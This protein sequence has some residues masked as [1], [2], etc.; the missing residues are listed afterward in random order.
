MSLPIWL[1]EL[2]HRMM[3]FLSILCMVFAFFTTTLPL[4]LKLSYSLSPLAVAYSSYYWRRCIVLLVGTLVPGKLPMLYCYV[5]GGLVCLKI[6]LLLFGVVPFVSPQSLALKHP[7]VNC[8]LL[9]FP[10]NVLR[11]GQ[12]ILLFTYPHMVDSMGFILVLMS[13]R[14][15]SSLSLFKLGREP[16][17]LL[18]YPAFSLSMLCDYLG[19]LMWFYMIVMLVLQPTFGA[20]YGNCWV[21]GLHYLWPTIHSLMG[22]PNI[23]IR[24]WNRLSAVF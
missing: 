10:A 22:R 3:H 6:C 4:S 7:Q 18:R 9:I 21:L 5:F 24:Q 16:Y 2:N 17:Q 19:S 15:L 20:V 8:T 14:S 1:L 23:L 11:Y 12:G 13:W